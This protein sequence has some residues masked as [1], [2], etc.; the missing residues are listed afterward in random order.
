LIVR[1]SVPSFLRSFV[2]A[3]FLRQSS[4]INQQLSI[5]NRQVLFVPSRVSDLDRNKS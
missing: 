5:V 1:S 4:I 2:P 3:S